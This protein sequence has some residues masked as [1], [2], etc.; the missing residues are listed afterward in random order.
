MEQS[1]IVTEGNDLSPAMYFRLIGHTH[2]RN[3]CIGISGLDTGQMSN[4]ANTIKLTNDY[5]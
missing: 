3:M 5:R 2:R 4:V 1:R